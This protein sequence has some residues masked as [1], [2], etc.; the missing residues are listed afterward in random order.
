MPR[1]PVAA[2]LSAVL[3]LV[4]V[5]G[6][7]AGGATATPSPSPLPTPTPVVASV[8]SAADAAARVIVT[9][10]R[11]AGAIQLR[12]D[13][14]GASRWWEAQALEGGAWQVSLTVGWG[15]CPAGCISRHTW[16][17]DVSADGLVQLRSESGEPVPS[18]LP[19]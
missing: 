11:F 14:I 18:V 3:A 17:Y 15:D 16:I 10:P 6:C 19:A 2:I 4:L 13:L 9:D 5:A 1:R 8:T 12:S 7:A